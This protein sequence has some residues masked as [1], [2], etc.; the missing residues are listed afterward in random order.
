MAASQKAIDTSWQ[1]LIWK[2]PTIYESSYFKVLTTFELEVAIWSH[3]TEMRRVAFDL[4]AP[5]VPHRNLL[6]TGV[7][8]T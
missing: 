8:S 5:I 3:I 6:L 1:F 4:I 7:F 2:I